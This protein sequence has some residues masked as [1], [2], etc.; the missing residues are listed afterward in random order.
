LRTAGPLGLRNN[1]EGSILIIGNCSLIV[2][3]LGK[4]RTV[5][6]FGS[7]GCT[8]NVNGTDQGRIEV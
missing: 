4:N 3:R 1:V 6:H 8:E 2:S 5:E 7:N